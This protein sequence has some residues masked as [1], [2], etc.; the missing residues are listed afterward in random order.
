MRAVKSA[1]ASRGGLPTFAALTVAFAATLPYLGTLGH[2]FALDDS[3]EIVRNEHVRSLGNVPAMFTSSAWAGSGEEQPIYRPLTSLTYAVN[4]ALGGLEAWGYHLA[5]LLLHAVASVLVL[6]LARRIGLGPI[7][8]TAS[9]VVF[10]VHPVH[11]E[12][13]ANIAGRKDALATIFAILAVLGHDA[14]LRRDLSGSRFRTALP[15]AALAAALLATGSGAA[16]IPM[17]LGFTLLVDPEPWARVRA[18][19]VALGAAY[20][21]VLALYLAARWN[22][23]GTFGVPPR[24]IPYVEN[25]IAHE[26]L[27]TRL[28]TAVAVIGKGLWT[29]AF[30]RWLSPD[31]S[32]DAIPLVRSA[33]D[34]R[35]LAS[36]AAV[37][38]ILAGAWLVRRVRP[39]LAYL[40]LWYGSG[41]FLTS[42]LVLRVGTIFGERLLYLPSVAFCIAGVWLVQ[43]AIQGVEPPDARVRIGRLAPATGIALL[44]VLA[45]RTYAYAAAWSD[46]VSLFEEAVR[47]AP[48]SA[49]VHQMLGAA[50]MEEGRMAEGVAELEAGLRLAAGAPA[51]DA[52]QGIQ[53]GVA[54][55][56][57]GRMAEAERAYS[58]V[59]AARP[60]EPDALWRLGVV[61]WLEGRRP[62]SEV[63][64]RRVLE[65]NP[66][67]ARAMTD[68]GLLLYSRGDVAGAVD[69]WRRAAE[70]DPLVA[71]PWLHLGSAAAARGDVDGARTAW[72]RFLELAHGAY[73]GQREV[74]EEK[75]RQL[76]EG[77]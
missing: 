45:A 75:L 36:L 51:V 11:V 31:W 65:V 9:A 52:G 25:P 59:L 2:G 61:R 57:A 77:R 60:D 56:R 63:L 33:V 8:S 66:R 14:A 23:L 37:A 19:V 20:L 13:V 26:D 42:N 5:N 72:R 38:A 40:T 43:H 39:G 15:V 29:L 30:P 71:G 3:L 1:G 32:Y 48:R 24:L 17:A 50:Y 47:A 76:D 73:P 46:E 4:F 6:A 74:V 21:S 69:L 53:L 34:P 12:V 62:E 55:E 10:A 64:W 28:L 67:H 16:A 18:R 7:A 41:A 22:A 27:A 49:K 68:L 44:L 58:E 54:Y 35:F 70:A